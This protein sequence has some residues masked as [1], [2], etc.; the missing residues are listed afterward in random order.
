MARAVP[1]SIYPREAVGDLDA[2]VRLTV[3]TVRA[4]EI[5]TSHRFPVGWKPKNR[6]YAC[7]EVIDT[8]CGI[9]EHEID[10]IFHPF[11]TNKFTGRGLGLPVVLGILHAHSGGLVVE[12]RKGRGSGSAFRAYLPV[13]AERVASPP[14]TVGGE[15]LKG[16]GWSGTVLLVE[17]DDTL[18]RAANRILTRL[19]FSVLDAKD[20]MDAVEVFRRHKD[21][22][23]LVLC[24]LT[25][26]NMDGWETWA[27]LRQLSP[28][29]PVILT[30]GY[31]E[32][33]VMAEDVTH[34]RRRS[35]RSPTG[36]TRSGA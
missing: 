5:P 19:G 11:F 22:V 1:H 27:A 24:D 30:S 15:E 31:D 29:I 7:L 6:V 35:W 12:S 17:D 4:S 23:R 10:K 8:G 16:A 20:G 21:T 25:M 33:H 9:A 36:S 32:A 18:R 3:K 26:P 14:A 2:T 34:T 13:S 28:A